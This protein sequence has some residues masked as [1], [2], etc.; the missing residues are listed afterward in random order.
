[1][2]NRRRGPH[3]GQM[4]RSLPIMHGPGIPETYERD[5]AVRS[6]EAQPPPSLLSN[7]AS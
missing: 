7:F 5:E 2:G 6:E 3:H 4:D 1:L